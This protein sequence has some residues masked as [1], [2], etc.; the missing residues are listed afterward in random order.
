MVALLRIVA[1]KFRHRW[2]PLRVVTAIA[3]GRL[4]I[5]EQFKAQYDAHE[6]S[7]ARMGAKGRPADAAARTDG[8]PASGGTPGSTGAGST[9]AHSTPSSSPLI[10][11][12]LSSSSSLS[13]L[14][15]S[16]FSPL[17]SSSPSPSL[18]LLASSPSLLSTLP[19]AALAP[20][21]TALCGPLCPQGRLTRFYDTQM[22]RFVLPPT[23]LMDAAA[24]ARQ[25]LSMTDHE[26]LHA[27]STSPL[28]EGPDFL[29]FIRSC[30]RLL[31]QSPD[32][33][34]LFPS[35][36]PASSALAARTAPPAPLLL[37]NLPFC[38]SPPLPP[39]FPFSCYR[40]LAQS[41]ETDTLF[42]SG[43]PRVFTR[44][45]TSQRWQRAPPP[46]PP[47]TP[48]MLYRAYRSRHLHS[49]SSLLC[50]LPCWPWL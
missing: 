47:R 27:N 21:C 24:L 22:D 28:A 10:P 15:S 13:L 25:R 38:S 6:R 39:A 45:P 37:L 26:L 34:T 36:A 44:D 35:G 48:L 49:L 31:A 8:S 16:S 40:L 41:P 32:S 3:L 23:R 43:A 18:P 50:S 33:D 30:Y 46:L 5:E 29:P 7:A 17:L 14:S 9:R 19:P 42:P 1:V 2:L 20:L 11:S 4:S 12:S